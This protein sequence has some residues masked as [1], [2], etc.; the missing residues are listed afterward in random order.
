MRGTKT[1]NY[2]NKLIMKKF[3]FL[4]VA[5]IA[6]LNMSAAITPMTC[7]EA[8]TAAQL[9]DHNVAGTDSVAVTGYV[10]NT[11]GKLSKGQQT[12]WMDDEKGS[13]KT[14]EGYWCNIPEGETALNVGDKVVIKGF[15]MRY[16][17][18]YEMKNGSI[19][20]L[21]RAI[22][23]IDT[24]QATVCE[25]VEECEAL[26][27]GDNTQDVFVVEG[28]VSSTPEQNDTYKTQKFNV[29]CE[30]NNKDLQ[31]YNVT[32]AEGY[33][34]LG[35]KVRLTGKLK[36]YGTTLEI[37]GNGVVLE[38]GSGIYSTYFADNNE[39]GV[40]STA[41]Y[42]DATGVLTVDLASNF[43]S[44]WSAQVKLHHKVAF[45]SQAKY[46]LSMKLHADKDV[47]NITI[48]MD[49]QGEAL[50]EN[51][52]I[53]LVAGEE[54]VY[55]SQAVQGVEGNNK[56]LVFDFGYGEAGT[57]IT[58]S[59]ITILVQWG[60]KAYYLTGDFNEWNIDAAPAFTQ[61]SATDYELTVP[62]IYGGV[63]VLKTQGTWFPHWGAFTS[64]DTIMPSSGFYMQYCSNSSSSTENLYVG[65]RG[66]GYVDA[67]FRI[68]MSGNNMTMAFVSGK[69]YALEDM[70]HSYYI[71]GAYCNWELQSAV[72]FEDEDGVLTANVPNLSGEF[73]VVQDQTWS[74]QWGANR[75]SEATVKMGEPYTMGAKTE[76]LGAPSNCTLGDTEYLN[77]KLTL[78]KSESG[79]MVLTLVSGDKVAFTCSVNQT[80]KTA[81]ITALLDK[82]LTEWKIPET[83]KG[84]DG[85]IY[86]VTEIAED[87]M[88]QCTN[89]TSVTIPRYVTKIGYGALAGCTSLTKITWNAIACSGI[90]DSNYG[91]SIYSH[92]ELTPYQ[93]IGDIRPQITSFIIGD[94]VEYLPSGLCKNMTNLTS[95]TIPASVKYIGE[96]FDNTGITSVVWNANAGDRCK[97]PYKESYYQSSYDDYLQRTYLP[98]QNIASQITSFTIGENVDSIPQGLCK[99]MANAVSFNIPQNIKFIGDDAFN[100]CTGMTDVTLGNALTY[101]GSNAFAGTGIASVS[102]PEG[103]TYMGSGA[104]ANTTNLKTIVWNVKALHG[105]YYRDEYYYDYY[106]E[107]EGATNS[108]FGNAPVTSFTFG[109][110]VD[111]IPSRLCYGMNQL[112]AIVVPDNTTMI[113]AEAFANTGITSITFPERLQ[114][115][116]GRACNNTPLT[117]IIWNVK[118][119]ND[120]NGYSYDNG[121]F[122]NVSSQITSFI[123][124]NNVE[125]IP[126]SLCKG[127]SQLTAIPLSANIRSIGR[128]AFAGTGITSITIPENVKNVGY[129]ICSET[130]LTTIVWNAV[131]A[132]VDGETLF[133]SVAEN[134]TSFTFGNKVR[135]IPYNLCWRMEKLTD[136]VIPTTVDSIEHAAFARCEGLTSIVIDGN[137]KYVEAEAFAYCTSLKKIEI[138]NAIEECGA[139]CFTGCMALDTLIT[140]A[141][142]LEIRPT[143]SDY[144][145]YLPKDIRY[146]KVTGGELSGN[147]F[148]V[149][150][151]NYKAL[152]TLDLAA[153]TNTSL[154]DEAFK[155]CYNLETLALPSAMEEIPYM[156]AAEC[157]SLKSVTIPAATKAIGHRAFENCRLLR[158]VL[159]AANGQLS[160][161][162]NWAFYNCHEL[163]SIAIPEGVTSVGYAAFYGCTYLKDISLPSTV[164]SI[165]DNGFAL[166]A[167][168]GKMTVNA[169]VPPV[170][171]AKTFENVS[172]S[173]PVY[174]PVQSVPQYQTADVW[175]EFNIQGVA[176]GVTSVE[177]AQGVNC[178]KIVRDGQVLI[179]RNGHTYSLTGV[180][181][182]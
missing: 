172:R 103:V 129:G 73:K 124:G 166:C 56:L 177:D 138:K 179:L 11:D 146:I 25:A 116:G 30:E 104:F 107:G 123:F 105:D 181:V 19:T 75:D 171:E 173:I 112:T 55:T 69:E 83:V 170:V 35:D 51:Q 149:I 90:W 71:V 144:N 98:F 150:N 59:D 44:Q 128:E 95:I 88:Y 82:T 33:A 160:T 100:G 66:M 14:F 127:M 24:I 22:V 152:R 122:G 131:S 72:K 117:T 86:K 148:E 121:R 34:A 97:S 42:D 135:F 16:N 52:S 132:H 47:K 45:N 165:A 180:M 12:F 141:N 87:A 23:K 94:E 164:E 67:K 108:M 26:A 65:K 153:T 169:A 49:D 93:T 125:V 2:F 130:P 157:V 41:T 159:F 109:E 53:N 29:T 106:G 6:T 76:T 119:L 161:I 74:V 62:A 68:S 154:S 7:A 63:K 126:N 31:A 81:T 61:V 57:H 114:T 78:V 17:D 145:S 50:Y 54:Y 21:E 36:K 85:T 163:Q 27:D 162:G 91:Y 176:T 80:D 147:A 39:T 113:G 182:E 38:K 115:L 64:K 175:K 3:L 110:N 37:I 15:L 48:K 46:M 101:I 156:M 10:T 32:M 89:L 118:N 111:S 70:P 143:S 137:L 120:D 136:I 167:K 9:L 60:N 99:G 8:A 79:D 142:M 174:V 158:D 5:L 20:I 168:L 58:I 40:S 133:S 178:S 84:S 151:R 102:I 1:N 4:W 96:E 13:K 43:S 134:I 18:V 77:A 92:V 139:Y 28:I 140:S 155:G